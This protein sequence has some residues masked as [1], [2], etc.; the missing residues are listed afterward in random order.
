M[1]AAVG[2]HPLN[3]TLVLAVGKKIVV[4]GRNAL[5]EKPGR[6]GGKQFFGRELRQ[7]PFKDRKKRLQ[8]FLQTVFPARTK[9]QRSGGV[10]LD[11]RKS[12]G[13]LHKR[14]WAI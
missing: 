8:L 14:H 3:Y 2:L 1:E 13:R 6:I 12:F 9:P 4:A 11:F 5:P 7:K 10:V